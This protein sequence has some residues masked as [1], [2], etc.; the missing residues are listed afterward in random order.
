MNINIITTAG[1]DEIYHGF[2]LS[3]GSIVKVRILDT[4]GQEQFDTVN[5][6]YYRNADCCLLVY[7]ITSV[8]SFEKI[9]NFYVKELKEKGNKIIKVILLGNKT[10]LK[11]ERKISLEEGINLAHQNGYIFK[12]TSCIDNYNVSDAFTTLIEMINNELIKNG[13]LLKKK[14]NKVITSIN[15]ENTPTKSG[16]KKNK[17]C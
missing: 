3:D 13:S 4:G 1:V 12:E 16:K 11:D 8:K 7:D 9:K 17:C 14:K 6:L 2:R 10:D 5:S 15:S